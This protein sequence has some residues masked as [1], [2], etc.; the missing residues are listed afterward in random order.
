[1]S[2]VKRDGASPSLALRA[3]NPA[4][5]L[6]PLLIIGLIVFALSRRQ[7]VSAAA[8]KAGDM[9]GRATRQAEKRKGNAT[10]RMVLSLLINM[11]ENDMARRGLIMGLKVARNR[12]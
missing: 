5:M 12:S 2:A 4:A 10:R 3:V 1:M 11:L 8:R 6:V 7:G 9:A